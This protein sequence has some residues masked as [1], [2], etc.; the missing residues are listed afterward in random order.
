VM[1]IVAFESDLTEEGSDFEG[2]GTVDGFVGTGGLLI[3]N[4]AA[5]VEKVFDH[6]ASVPEEGIAQA[7]FEPVSQGFE[8]FFAEARGDLREEGLGFAVPFFEACLPE[9]FFEPGS[10][11]L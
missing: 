10:A 9:F 6:L 11:P 3:G 7:C 2:A 5:V 1:V 4:Q 8:S